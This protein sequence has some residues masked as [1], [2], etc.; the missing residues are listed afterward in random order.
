MAEEPAQPQAKPQSPPPGTVNYYPLPPSHIPW[1][2]RRPGY[3]RCRRIIKR[4]LRFQHLVQ[5]HD[6]W[7]SYAEYPPPLEKLIGKEW[8]QKNPGI[9]TERQMNKIAP[10][11]VRDM[12]LSGISHRVKLDLDGEKRSLSLVT[13]YLAFPED[14]RSSKFKSLMH[15]LDMAVGQYEDRERN[16]VRDC[17][18][19]LFWVAFVLRMPITILEYAGLIT[20]TEHHSAWVKFYEWIGRITF[21]FSVVILVAYVAAR[22]GFSV[23]WNVLSKVVGLGG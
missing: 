2:L 11:V 15:R 23:P 1:A 21:G 10:Q 8:I 16:A 14:A 9:E 18:N 5:Q 4:L 3:W 6:K 12:D 22:L 13:D 17:F 19:P 20:T 7:A